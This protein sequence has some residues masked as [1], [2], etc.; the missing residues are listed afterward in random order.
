MTVTRMGKAAVLTALGAGAAVARRVTTRGEVPSPAAGD[1]WH[2]VTVN[3]P[4]EQLG[5]DPLAALGDTAEVRLERAPGDRGTELHARLRAGADATR[6][7]VRELRTA[8]RETKMR[9]ET[10]EVLTPA[11]PGTSTPTPLNAPLRAATAHGRGEGR[12]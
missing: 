5:R 11:E 6:E 2:A 8:L 10:G 3:L 9:L 4:P 7:Q 1:R 12:L